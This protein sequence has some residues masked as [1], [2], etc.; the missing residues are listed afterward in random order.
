[1]R[2]LFAATFAVVMASLAA[3]GDGGEVADQQFAVAAKAVPA[4]SG[5]Q[6]LWNVRAQGEPDGTVLELEGGDWFLV[7]PCGEVSGTWAGRGGLF[8]ADSEHWVNSDP[9][10]RDPQSLCPPAERA[11]PAWMGLVVG[12]RQEGGG[13]DLLDASGSTVVELDEGATW[14]ANHRRDRIFMEFGGEDNPYPN[15]DERARL[16]GLPAAALPAGVRAPLADDLLGRWQLS[17][18]VESVCKRPWIQF[19]RDGKWTGSNVSTETHGTWV[20]GAGGLALATAGPMNMSGCSTYEGAPEIDYTGLEVDVW[21]LR[22]ARLGLDG[23]ELV[24]YDPDGKELARTTRTPIPTP[25][26]TPEPPDPRA[27]GVKVPGG[28]RYLA[29]YTEHQFYLSSGDHFPN[30]EDDWPRDTI[31]GVDR[32]GK[33]AVVLT[34]C[35]GGDVWVTVRPRTTPP[36]PL[37]QSMRGWEVGEENTMVINKPLSA[38]DG[39]EWGEDVYTPTVPG[40][41]RVRMLAKG[42]AIAYDEVCDP[43]VEEYEITIW[44]V[45]TKEPRERRADDGV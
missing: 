38:Y 40:L 10:P 27:S 21:M 29:S 14:P 7:R 36:P 30:F 19:A 3:C 16:N 4:E 2:R 43:P 34:G 17:G 9:D 28:V 44:P 13:W 18:A 26:P 32:S 8:L 25:T 33:G 42:R 20:L 11:I 23:A 12:Y 35:W 24:F 6:G 39:N 31:L 37:A 5:L 41:H 22:L 15:S 1:M 45:L